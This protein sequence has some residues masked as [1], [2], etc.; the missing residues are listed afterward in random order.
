M[1]RSNI[2]LHAAV[3]LRY[4]I[5][6]MKQRTIEQTVTKHQ[7]VT[8]RDRTTIP[9]L[10]PGTPGDNDGHANFSQDKPYTQL[11]K[12]FGPDFLK[13]GGELNR[14][15]RRVMGHKWSLFVA[16]MQLRDA[17]EQGQ[18][19]EIDSAFRKLVTAMLPNEQADKATMAQHIVEFW[20]EPTWSKRTVP[21]NLPPRWS[22]EMGN[23]RFVLWWDKRRKR[24]LPAFYCD[25]YTSAVFVMGVLDY[26]RT[27]AAS[28]CEKVFIPER[29]DQVYH[30]M[31]CRERHRMRRHRAK[32]KIKCI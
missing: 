12:I 17:Y 2:H 31:A 3:L 30:E 22:T 15:V 28:D 24:F 11:V 1:F 10:V 25:N 29:E 16:A 8:D 19:F 9:I 20:A 27:C 32:L 4:N 18:R 21:M 13:V 23:A 5:P 14:R 6:T 26:V 7:T